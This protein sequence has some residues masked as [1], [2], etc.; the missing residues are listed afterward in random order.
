MPETGLM[1]AKRTGDHGFETIMDVPLVLG[2]V[3]RDTRADF[4]D[5]APF[6][7]LLGAARYQTEADMDQNGAFDFLDVGPFIQTLSQ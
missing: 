3:N 7:S 4:L 6:V 5:L 2:D 1:V